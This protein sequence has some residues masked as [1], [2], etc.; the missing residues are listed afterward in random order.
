MMTRLQRVIT[1][2]D[3]LMATYQ[4]AVTAVEAAKC[5][6]LPSGPMVEHAKDLIARSRVLY[7]ERSVLLD[8]MLTEPG[9]TARRE[10][11]VFRSWVDGHLT[12]DE[13]EVLL[14]SDDAS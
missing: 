3:R 12:Y 1:L 14:S 9:E 2:S 10:L 6:G 13:L 5:L 8:Q 7:A 11:E 4:L